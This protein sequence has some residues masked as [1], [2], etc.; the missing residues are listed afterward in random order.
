MATSD[1]SLIC[2]HHCGADFAPR[3][4]EEDNWLMIY[5]IQHYITLH[6]LYTIHSGLCLSVTINVVLLGS[7]NTDSVIEIQGFL[8]HLNYVRNHLIPL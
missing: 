3:N 7:C 8:E 4:F 2:T 1:M 5:S 6:T